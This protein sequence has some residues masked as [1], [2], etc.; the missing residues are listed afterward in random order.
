MAEALGMGDSPTMWFPGVVAQYSLFRA[1]HEKEIRI[2]GSLTTFQFFLI[3]TTSS[4]AYYIIPNYLFPSISALSFI[5]WI[6]RDS[7]TAQIIG[8]GRKG[9]GIGSFSLD[10]TAIVSFL[11][12]PLAMPVFT[13]VNMMAGFILIVYIITPIAYWTNAYNAKRFPIFSLNVYDEDGN[14]YNVSRIINENKFEFDQ[15]AYDNYSKIYLSSYNVYYHAFEFAG[16]AA[17]IIHVA[18]YHGRDSSSLLEY[19]IGM[20]TCFD[21]YTP[22]VCDGSNYKS[23]KNIC[24]PDKLPKGSPWSCP[25][26]R[27]SF[28]GNVIW[29]LVGPS[30]VFFPS[31][32][33]SKLFISF[34]IGALAPVPMWLLAR[35][36]PDKQWIKLINIPLIL[37]GATGM[38]PATTLAGPSGD[39]AS[40]PSPKGMPI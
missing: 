13:L 7:I 34:I 19:S 2:K 24:E 16:V 15:T 5:C 25:L 31:G 14:I 8:S 29:G 36:F 10:W 28:M 35:R 37:A 32:Q 6:W 33:Y 1:L 17:T 30:N 9:L 39:H 20:W 12:N 40:T 38:P 22:C 27:Q 4:F 11:G 21:M 18:M 23:V 3:A 26:E